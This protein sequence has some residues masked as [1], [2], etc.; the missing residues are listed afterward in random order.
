MEAG[1]DGA[2]EI[3]ADRIRPIRGLSLVLGG[4]DARTIAPTHR[5]AILGLA[6]VRNTHGEPDSD[7]Q[8]GDRE[9][10]SRDIGQHAA[11][12]FVRLLRHLLITCEVE[13]FGLHGFVVR[14]N[15]GGCSQVPRLRGIARTKLEHTMLAFRRG[16]PLCLHG[17]RLRDVV[18]CF[19]SNT[20]ARRLTQKACDGT[21][22][23]KGQHRLMCMSRAAR[24]VDPGY[25]CLSLDS[26]MKSAV[27]DSQ[28]SIVRGI[29]DVHIAMAE[30]DVRIFIGLSRMDGLRC[31]NIVA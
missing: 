10:K 23:E 2:S 11:T 19:K 26:V 18:E 1:R 6:H 13:R 25:G 29:E 28:T 30:P 22:A 7:G 4:G 20:S 9:C 16:G 31:N 14:L 5:Y 27:V 3:A 15:H 17:C 12:K 21:D 24:I 8:E